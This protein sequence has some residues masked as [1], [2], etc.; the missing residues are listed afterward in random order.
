MRIILFCPIKQDLSYFT[1]LLDNMQAISV[2]DP[3]THRFF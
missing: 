1:K 3:F 2:L